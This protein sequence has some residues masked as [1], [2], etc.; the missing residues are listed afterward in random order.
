[1]TLKSVVLTLFYED[2]G[3]RSTTRKVPALCQDVSD[4]FRKT[5]LENLFSVTLR[6]FREN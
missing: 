5:G 6:D 3:I 2:R 1:M 4:I